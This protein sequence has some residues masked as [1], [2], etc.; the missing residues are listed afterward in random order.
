[1]NEHVTLLPPDPRGNAS[2]DLGRI[3]GRSAQPVCRAPPRSCSPVRVRLLHGRHLPCAAVLN[4]RA[5]FLGSFVQGVPRRHRHRG[6]ECSSRRCP[7]SAAPLRGS[8]DPRPRLQ[9][10]TSYATPPAEFADP[11][12][13]ENH[14]GNPGLSGYRLGRPVHGRLPDLPAPALWPPGIV[15][16]VPSSSVRGGVGRHLGPLTPVESFFGLVFP[17]LLVVGMAM[18]APA[19]STSLGTEVKR[20]RELASYR[21]EEKLGESG[22]GEVWRARHRI[23]HGRP[24]SSSSALPSPGRRVP[25]CPGAADASSARRR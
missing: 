5:R 24:P 12:G 25:V 14:R 22:I 17:Y 15:S 18:S 23:R 13:L 8:D 9:I 1:M 21:L 20:A 7:Q 2:R 19:S 10:V 3:A 4:D 6:G 16:S 11:A